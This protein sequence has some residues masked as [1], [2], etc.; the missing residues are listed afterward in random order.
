MRYV[1]FRIAERCGSV[2]GIAQKGKT[3]KSRLCSYLM[4]SAGFYNYSCKGAVKS[5]LKYK[6][7]CK[8]FNAA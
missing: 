6:A 4:A 8:R 7:G 1:C 5:R 3:A 2:C